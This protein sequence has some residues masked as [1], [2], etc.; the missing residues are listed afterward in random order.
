MGNKVLLSYISEDSGH[1]CASIAIEKAL[2]SISPGIETMN[3]NLF[4]YINPLMEK[5]INGAYMSVVKRKPEI[6]DYLYDNPK[7][8]RQVQ[9][10]RKRIHKVNTGKLKILLD[11]FKPDGVIC[12]QAFPCGLIADYKK[13][14]GVEIPLIGVLTDYAPHSYWVFD[15]VD[16]YIVP[17]AETGKKLI[18]NGIEPAKILDYG[19]PIEAKFSSRLERND[20]FR[21]LALDKDSSTLLV[22][23]GTQGLGPLKEL[24]LLLDKSPLRLNIII[25]CGTNKKLYRWLN[26]RVKNFRKRTIVLPFADNI[27]E[28]MEISDI[29]V[30]KPGGITTAEALAKGLPMLIINPLPGQEAMNTKF[31]LAEGVA[32]KA[33]SP[34]DAAVLVEELLYNKSKLRTMSDK[35]RSLSKPDSVVNIAKMMME[36]MKK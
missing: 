14:F 5:L 6:W 10:L 16:R 29:I 23:G 4:N 26:R 22:M 11:E 17:S 36:L 7:V 25:A 21:K 18:D 30:T 28:L 3:I 27:D 34:A 15:S 31:L 35:A 33:E 32:I 19:I 12:T 24:V 1:H 13:T 2:H 20:I 8:L 9:R